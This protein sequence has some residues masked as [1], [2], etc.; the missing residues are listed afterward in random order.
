M[1]AEV[2]DAPGSKASIEEARSLY[3]KHAKEYIAR[4]DVTEKQLEAAVPLS[5]R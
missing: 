3:A 5:S 1:Q 2:G 4:D